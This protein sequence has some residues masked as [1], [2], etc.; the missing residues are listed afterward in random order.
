MPAVKPTLYMNF[1]GDD[2]NIV[3]EEDVVVTADKR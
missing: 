1:N 2:I 3:I